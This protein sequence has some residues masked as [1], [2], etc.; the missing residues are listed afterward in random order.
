M[1]NT[2]RQA[3]VA[4]LK[5]LRIALQSQSVLEELSEAE[6]A[7]ND[8][9]T[10]VRVECIDQV[11]SAI[12]RTD[13]NKEQADDTPIE[14]RSVPATVTEAQADCLGIPSALYAHVIAHASQWAAPTFSTTPAP[15]QHSE[16][17]DRLDAACEAAE[18]Y[19]SSMDRTTEVGDFSHTDIIRMCR[20]ILE[21][22]A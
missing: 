2:E 14:P 10:L 22:I 21:A 18:N 9:V 16:L 5:A 15:S 1:D 20:A 19:I 12:E 13:H 8:F 11:L 4:Y 7:M 6:K 17:A 3:I